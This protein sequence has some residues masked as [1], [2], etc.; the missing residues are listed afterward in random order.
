MEQYGVNLK[1]TL[2]KSVNTFILQKLNWVLLVHLHGTG[3]STAMLKECTRT[4]YKTIQLTQ[5]KRKHNT[6]IANNA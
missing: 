5:Y 4:H 3:F 2:E 1:V 6:V